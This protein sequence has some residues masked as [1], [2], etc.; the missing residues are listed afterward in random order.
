MQ[1]RALAIIGASHAGV[2]TAEALRRGGYDGRILLFSADPAALP[3]HRPPLSKA[4][5][6]GEKAA[7]QIALRGAS[8]YAD[9][10]IEL[11]TGSRVTDLDLAARCVQA[12]GHQHPV[13]HIILAC[14]ARARNLPGLTGQI[15]G[16]H[17]L[18]TLSDADSLA[19]RTLAGGRLVIAGGGF[20][21]LEVAATLVRRGVH[22]TIIEPQ[23]A[24]LRRA[25]PQAI[26]E[27]LLQRHRLE[28][29]DIRPGESIARI[30][31]NNTELCAVHL[32]DGTRL[33]TDD[34]LVGIGSTARLE[35]AQSA[36]LALH[37]D[38]VQVNHAG[39]TSASGVHAIGDCATQLNRFAS[40]WIRLESVQAANEQAR[41][42]AAHI[43][44][45]PD[46]PS[47]A[48]AVPWFWSDQ[49]D[50]KLQI[51][52]L[53]RPAPQPD[54]QT[55]IRQQPDQGSCTVLQLKAGILVAAASV[56]RPADHLQA[57]KLIASA[58]HLDPHLL[59]DV[60]VALSDCRMAGAA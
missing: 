60:T 31:T 58:A 12:A 59:A 22:V 9:T 50:W 55:V 24:L 32:S 51:A 5:L 6:A 23:T 4:Y 7:A 57:R 19:G 39:R 36:G 45:L 18:R 16:I 11:I 8:F 47:A 35:L 17:C 40:G 29:V 20:I 54:L 25:L 3:Y 15:R 48:N 37:M 33:A 43:L 2:T 26:S 42:C 30:E 27:R 10:G 53:I 28:G 49:F 52:G 46:A 14:G 34:L 13:D 21:G 41:A 38:G 1:N 56:N 44:D